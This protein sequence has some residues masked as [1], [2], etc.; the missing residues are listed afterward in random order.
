MVMSSQQPALRKTKKLPHR[1]RLSVSVDS[2]RAKQS[3]EDDLEVE[4][5]QEVGWV[6]DAVVLCAVLVLVPVPR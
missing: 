1:S 6:V 2:A 4:V 5:G 3:D